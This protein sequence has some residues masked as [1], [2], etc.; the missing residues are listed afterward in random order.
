MTKITIKTEPITEAQVKY[1][2]ILLDDC[3]FNLTQAHS[4][5]GAEFGTK[6]LYKLTSSQG[7]SAITYLKNL[8]Q[9]RKITEEDED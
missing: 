2:I 7:S 1:I 5:L 4:W 9:Q 6:D 8:K 3:G